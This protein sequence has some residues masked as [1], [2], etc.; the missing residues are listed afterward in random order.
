MALEGAHTLLCG[1]N[2]FLMLP[3]ITNSKTPKHWRNDSEKLNLLRIQRSIQKNGCHSGFGMR[4]LALELGVSLAHLK[5]MLQV[6]QMPPAGKLIKDHQ[7]TVAKELLQQNQLSVKEIAYQVGF[8]SSGSFCRAFK[9][10]F[11]CSPSAYQNKCL[12]AKKNAYKNNERSR[13]AGL[14]DLLLVAQHH[15]WL[16]KTLQVL[17]HKLHEDGFGVEWLARELLISTTQL[18]RQFKQTVGLSPGKF[19]RKIRLLL[20]AEFLATTNESI[21]TIA[22]ETGF[23]D[24]AHFCRTFKREFKLSP[25]AFRQQKNTPPGGRLIQEMLRELIC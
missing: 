12:A 19:I 21:S 10:A 8:S 16:A 6:A 1:G 4:E 25:G 3:Q 9:G 22:I 13:A 15:D 14:E 11:G 20:A 23:A 2:T 17:P 5:R 18:N 7:F 24:T